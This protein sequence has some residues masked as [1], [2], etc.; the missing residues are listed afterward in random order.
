[1]HKQAQSRMKVITETRK[2]KSMFSHATGALHSSSPSLPVR[3]CLQVIRGI[4]VEQA[5]CDQGRKVGDRNV[6]L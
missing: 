1:M 2:S 4:K 3:T 6:A 5:E